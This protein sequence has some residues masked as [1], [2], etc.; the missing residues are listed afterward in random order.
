MWGAACGAHRGGRHPGFISRQ[1][2][3]TWCSGPL[4]TRFPRTWCSRVDG[5]VLDDSTP[6]S[7]AAPVS[8]GCS[9]DVALTGDRFVKV[10]QKQKRDNPSRS[11]VDM[12]T[13]PPWALRLRDVALAVVQCDG[14][15]LQH[16]D[17]SFRNDNRIVTAAVR[18]HVTHFNTLLKTC[19]RMRMW[20]CRHC[21]ARHT[22]DSLWNPPMS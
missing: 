21:S 22:R 15:A 4:P 17:V 13:I 6:L 14:K 11:D 5:V 12:K 3:S 10:L 9:I 20:C 8:H 7:G 18:S 1:T 16:L 2:H 19:V